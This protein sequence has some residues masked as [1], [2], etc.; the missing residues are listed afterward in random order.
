MPLRGPSD[1]CF[2]TFLMSSYLAAFSGR[3]VRSTTDTL[4]VGTWKD[5]P[6]SF[7]FS[8]GMTLPTVL[9]APVE[10]G[11]MFWAAPR[12]SHHNFPEGPSTVF[13]VAVMAW[14]VV[15]RPSTMPKW[16]WMTLARGAKQLVG[17]GVAS[18]QLRGGRARQREREREGGRDRV[19]E[20]FPRGEEFHRPGDDHSPSSSWGPPATSQ[21]S[22]VVLGLRFRE[23]K[24]TDATHDHRQM[25]TGKGGHGEAGD[26]GGVVRARG[27]GGGGGASGAGTRVAAAAAA[28]SAAAGDGGGELWRCW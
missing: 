11:M 6:V 8:L 27:A 21:V 26:R 28:A 10:A 25:R 12:P 4:G 14:T 16:S 22:G 13:W 15:M 24:G 3:Q 7:L 23:A 18:R 5:M 2:T 19:S 1:A 17:A 20:L 9:A